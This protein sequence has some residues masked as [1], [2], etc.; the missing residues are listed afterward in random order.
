MAV[1]VRITGVNGAV[2]KIKLTGRAVEQKLPAALKRAGL[3][4]QRESMKLVPVQ[5]GPL[6]ASAFTRAEGRGFRTRVIVGY[7]AAYA[8]Y[9]HEI[10]TAAHGK[11]YNT[12]YAREI[13]AAKTPAEKKI[14]FRRGPNQQAK[15]LETPARTRQAEIA[16]IIIKGTRTK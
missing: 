2:Q 4:L 6:K 7:T 13:A 16:D 9:V 5:Y 3:F 11:A 10:T 14:W 12:K 1:I 8:I 15:F